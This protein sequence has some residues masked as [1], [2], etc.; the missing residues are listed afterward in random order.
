M[1][2]LHEYANIN[3]ALLDIRAR[4]IDGELKNKYNSNNL[5]TYEYD[6]PKKR[7]NCPEFYAHCEKGKIVN[8]GEAYQTMIK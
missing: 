6:A 5:K 3:E 1:S 7:L 2:G 8:F 4:F